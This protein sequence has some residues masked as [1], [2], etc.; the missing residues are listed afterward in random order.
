MKRIP[1]TQGFFAI[2]DDEDYE[3]VS[4][5]KWRAIVQGKSVH[6]A[7]MI[8]NKGK[9]LHIKMHRFILNAPDGMFVDHINYNCLDN[10]RVNIRLCTPQ[11][12][13]YHRRGIANSSS[14]YKGIWRAG[15]KKW[16][17]Q[18]KH[19]NKA[20]YIGQYNNEIKAAKAYDVKARELFGKFAE[21]NF[22]N[23]FAQA[24]EKAI[25]KTNERERQ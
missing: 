10:K 13:S 7:R 20:I 6:A 12:S 19:N 14:K 21:L 9:Q 17:A 8:W 4:K 5:F 24:A 25:A 23:T 16:Q 3:R 22:P 15:T 1:L 2:V 11:E 18:I